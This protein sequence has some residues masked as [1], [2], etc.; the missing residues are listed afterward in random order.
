VCGI[1]YVSPPSYDKN[2]KSPI[3]NIWKNLP[4]MRKE[5]IFQCKCLTF[6][7]LPLRERGNTEKCVQLFTCPELIQG[8]VCVLYL[9]LG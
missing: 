6:P 1:S 9:N 8:C 5:H 4:S 3:W 2:S 7:F